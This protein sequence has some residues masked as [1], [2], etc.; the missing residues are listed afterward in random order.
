MKTLRAPLPLALALLL[1]LASCSRRQDAPATGDAVPADSLSQARAAATRQVAGVGLDSLTVRPGLR[2]AALPLGGADSLVLTRLPSRDGVEWQARVMCADGTIEGLE[3]APGV[4][5]GA[6]TADL[7][8][9]GTREAVWV[10]ESDA[11]GMTVREVR[12]Y[13]PRAGRL[14]VKVLTF[15]RDATQPEPGVMGS[16]ELDRA[17]YAL[18]G[19][20]I[21]RVAKR[22]G[23]V[24]EAELL[25]RPN[26]PSRAFYYWSHDNAGL[27]EGAPMRVRRFRGA[28]RLGGATDDTLSARGVLYTAY[29][30]GGLVAY[31]PARDEHWVVFHPQ[32]A[33]AWPSCL[34]RAGDVL[35]IGTHGEG[36]AFVRLP[37]LELRHARL[38]G[39]DDA[40]RELAVDGGEVTVN[41]RLKVT[42]PRF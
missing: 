34:A 18:E 13:C 42:I 4:L 30:R 16:D 6:L 5:V 37:D 41:G 11:A 25:E 36:L 12:L 28:P 2:R 3:G 27:A 38:A 8:A 39:A 35:V 7:H 15:E 1:A 40:V 22:H 21:D 32:E 14:L 29:E 23:A 17:E 26:D 33:S 19:A 31:D 9:D 20:L 10:L 24:T